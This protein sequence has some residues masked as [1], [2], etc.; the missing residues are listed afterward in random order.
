LITIANLKLLERCILE[1]AVES[2]GVYFLHLLFHSI[3]QAISN[4]SSERKM[5]PIL[6]VLLIFI[7]LVATQ[8]P[9]GTSFCDYY[10]GSATA[11]NA[12]NAQITWI[13]RFT[14]NVF[15]GNSSVFSGTTV[16]GVLSAGTY[17]SKQIRLVKYFDGSLYNT[18]GVNGLPQ[19]VNWLDDGGQVALADG[20]L[21]N[22][23]T[24]N[25]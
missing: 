20:R 21:A 16:Q 5:Q 15:G 23:Q 11:S 19:A 4:R 25:Q 1:L 2:F 9:N 12:T 3:C 10:S 14:V 6:V 22:S 7:P 24:S 13:T 8:A 18:D 17:N